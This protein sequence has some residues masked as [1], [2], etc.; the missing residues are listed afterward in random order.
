MKDKKMISVYKNVFETTPHANVDINDFLTKIGQEW[1][2][3]NDMIQAI[4]ALDPLSSSAAEK[5]YKSLKEKLPCCT[6]S[7]TFRP[8]RKDNDLE[9]HSG[10]LALDLDRKEGIN[11]ILL[12][13]GGLE[14]VIE[15]LKR[16]PW[17]YAVF[18]S[19]GGRSPCCIVKIPA[20]VES[21]VAAFEALERYFLETYE[22]TLDSSC[23]NVGHLRFI[24]SDPN[25]YINLNAEV[26]QIRS[27][28][29]VPKIGINSKNNIKTKIP[30]SSSKIEKQKI[31][32]LV[33][34]IL[35]RL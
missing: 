24:S 15:L 6:I 9:D 17:V 30:A 28:S 26:Y 35:N 1:P 23:K 25:L 21:H 5:R 2:E 32:N 22:L 34:R 16:E 14:K 31:F 3:C 19:V 29:A 7:G 33:E 13:E 20:G 4:R 10:Y 12:Q 18:K 11:Q 8:G 27:A